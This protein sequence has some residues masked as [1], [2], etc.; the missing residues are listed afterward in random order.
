MA[1]NRKTKGKITINGIPTRG[2]RVKAFD[3]DYVSGTPVFSSCLGETTTDSNGNY[4]ISYSPN[5]YGGL[6]GDEDNIDWRA[7]KPDLYIEVW[8]GVIRLKKS[9]VRRDVTS[10]EVTINLNIQETIQNRK[11]KGKI[12]INGVPTRGLTVKAYDQDY[13][14]GAPVFSSFLGETTT[15]SNGNYSISYSPNAYGGLPGD[16]DN[17]D[18][19][20]VKPDLYIEVWRGVIRLKKSSVRRDVTSEEVTINLNIQETIQNRKTKGKITINGVP[21][22][23]LTVKAYDQ[24][25]PLGAPVFSSFLGET[26]TDSNGNYSISY[27]PNAYGGL[28]GDEDNIDWRA[29]KPDL[30]IE[31]WRGVI[32]L[33]KSSVRRDV[34]SEEVTIN[35]NIQETIQNR[36]T[37][38]KIT[39]NGV[40]TRGLTVKAYDQ[41]YPLG[42]PVFSSFLGETTTDSN[43]NYSI[44]YSPNAYGGLPGDEDNIDWRP[45]KPDLYIEVMNG[46]TLLK[47]SS[48]ARDVASEEIEINIDIPLGNDSEPGEWHILKMEYNEKEKIDPITFTTNVFARVDKHNGFVYHGPFYATK[49][50][51]CLEYKLTRKIALPP[52]DYADEIQILDINKSIKYR[53]I[54]QGNILIPYTVSGNEINVILFSQPSTLLDNSLHDDNYLRIKSVEFFVPQS[55]H[56]EERFPDGFIW[57]ASLSAFQ[58]EGDSHPVQTDWEAWCDGDIS[59]GHPEPIGLGADHYTQYKGDFTHAANLGFKMMR[60]GI[61]WARIEPQQNNFISIEVDHYKSV[62][63]YLISKGIEPMITLHHFS[64]PI[65]FRNIGGFEKEENIQCF[66]NYLEFIVPQLQEW[67]VRYFNTINEPMVYATAGWNRPN[68]YKEER[69]PPG[70]SDLLL[71]ITV[72]L[73]LLKAHAQAYDK[74]H[75]LHNNAKVSAVKHMR[76]MKPYKGQVGSQEEINE[77][78]TA[79]LD[80]FFNQLFIDAISKGILECPPNILQ[81]LDIVKSILPIDQ[82][83]VCDQLKSTAHIDNIKGSIDFFAVNYYSCDHIYID[84]LASGEPIV[85]NYNRAE[86]EYTPMKKRWE[87]YPQGIYEV[88][89]RIHKNFGNSF[90]TKYGKELE[91]IFITE[92]GIGD[93]YPGTDTEYKPSIRSRFIVDHLHFLHK[94]ISEGID[95]RGYLHWSLIDNFELNEGY[96]YCFGLL[97]VDCR[98]DR[99]VRRDRKWKRSAFLYQKIIKQNGLTNTIKPYIN[100]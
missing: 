74:I 50:R 80:Y 32:R 52:F 59:Q 28:P 36:K 49:V 46:D 9:S 7:V 5:A 41:D 21:T 69:F 68:E 15:D 26:T 18:W 55:C 94:A 42:A 1:Q 2:L 72:Y 75:E 88:A 99:L 65:W 47:K 35:L 77:G 23:G 20:A 34:T 22:R 61:E 67:G 76:M 27:S 54:G 40:P 100:R 38:G 89:K 98:K 95:V 87:Y 58:A 12:T 11:T 60:I 79:I 90:K 51:V 62:I 48:V 39:I 82:Q 83:S 45:V 17:I 97:Q 37:K 16:E 93:E 25:Y 10:E 4:S 66:I 96:K 71:S 43:G 63:Q 70:K 31:V 33:K 64:I 44:S 85:F 19:R 86:F 6:P 24:D 91:G 57:G 53:L 30:Y 14:L 13:P 73:N 8:R 3:Q 78:I 29:V 56:I 84:L 92:N 81:C